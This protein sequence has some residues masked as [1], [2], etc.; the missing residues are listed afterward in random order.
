MNIRV[1]A[2][3]GDLRR[4][5]DKR[6]WQKREGTRKVDVTRCFGGDFVQLCVFLTWKK[7]GGNAQVP[8]KEKTDRGRKRDLEEGDR[9][10]EGAERTY[11]K[12][13]GQLCKNKRNE[14]ARKRGV[15]SNW[16]SIRA[17]AKR[18][19]SLTTLKKARR[20]KQLNGEI[21]TKRREGRGGAGKGSIQSN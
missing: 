5:N 9:G 11:N 19:R 16:P 21:G 20:K 17:R 1:S 15:T 2:C 6:D 4:R 7:G 18:R 3:W 13:R 8:N 12:R 14:G 10:G